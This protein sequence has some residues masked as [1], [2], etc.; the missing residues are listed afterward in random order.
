MYMCMC[1]CMEHVVLDEKTTDVHAS[2][3]DTHCR[4]LDEETH[5]YVHVH[6]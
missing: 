1:K 4:L 6:V 3:W 2:A 5:L